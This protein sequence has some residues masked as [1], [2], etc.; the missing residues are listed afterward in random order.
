MFDHAVLD[1][2]ALGRMWPAGLVHTGFKP[3]HDG[4]S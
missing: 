4:R 1:V 3:T 2:T